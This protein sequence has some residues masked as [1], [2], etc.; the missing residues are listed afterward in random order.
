M[1]GAVGRCGG[2]T[3][4][5]ALLYM[6]FL[7]LI[8]C[9]PAGLSSPP[10]F[11]S[12]PPPSSFLTRSRSPSLFGIVSPFLDGLDYAHWYL[13][14]VDWLSRWQ[15]FALLSSF[16][17]LFVLPFSAPIPFSRPHTHSIPTSLLLSFALLSFSLSLSLVSPH[18]ASFAR[19]LSSLF[20]VSFISSC[21]SR[22]EWSTPFSDVCVSADQ[23]CS[24][25][26]NATPDDPPA[27]RPRVWLVAFGLLVG[28]GTGRGG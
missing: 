5:R 8:W 22:C 2:P 21:V 18:L 23:S 25:T 24:R 16:L 10:P 20:C 11:V 28:V 15:L 1:F 27:P 3:P 9:V 7:A 14:V 13:C 12:P 17:P 19:S 6:T 26:H 4:D